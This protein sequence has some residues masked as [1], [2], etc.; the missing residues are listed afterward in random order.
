MNED[1]CLSNVSRETFARLKTFEGLVAKWTKRIN[2][3]SKSDSAEIWQRH[4]LD[5]AQ[6]FDLAPREGLWLDIG[7]G[8][9]F[10]GL[11][12]AIL[13]A[14]GGRREFALVDSDQRK[15]AFLRSAAREL[16]LNVKVY[17]ERIEE[18]PA[19]GAAVLSARALGPLD[20]LLGFAERHLDPGGVA[21]FP[22]G[23]RWEK[24]VDEARNQWSY[25][26][27]TT[28]SLTNPDA[29]ILRITE[30]TRA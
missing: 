8:G 4:I 25:D 18:L 20:T 2:L 28:T 29:T 24:E 9:G 15:C 5:S 23:A 3:V 30:L 6:I 1:I 11:V 13:D 16:D 27:K 22:K 12:C 10:P 17:A 26:L 21:L 19:Q 14:D 7:S